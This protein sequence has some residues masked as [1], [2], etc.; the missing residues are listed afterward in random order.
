[1]LTF[2]QSAQLDAPEDA[3]IDRLLA[4][5]TVPEDLPY[6]G[7][8]ELRELG[9]EKLM[10]RK[11]FLRHAAALPL[12]PPPPPPRGERPS[13]RVPATADTSKNEL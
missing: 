8:S 7:D 9:M 5:G 1:M 12:P 3:Y 10:H 6:M 11:R 13:E 4:G 2:L